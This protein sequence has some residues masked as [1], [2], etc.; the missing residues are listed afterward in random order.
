MYRI[1]TYSYNQAKKLGVKIYPSDKPK[2]KIKV[3]TNDD[4][5]IYIGAT[6]YSDYPTYLLTHGKE[7]ADR[8]RYLYRKR[9]E[10]YRNIVGTPSYFADKILW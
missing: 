4:K 5:P 3:I 7:Y 9:H 2:Y 6:G 10:K 8:R 1:L